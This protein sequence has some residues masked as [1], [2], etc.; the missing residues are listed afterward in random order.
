MLQR[1]LLDTIILLLLL[2]RVA[3]KVWLKN[4]HSKCGLLWGCACNDESH[5]LVS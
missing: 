5:T 1:T 3:S 2:D 4:T